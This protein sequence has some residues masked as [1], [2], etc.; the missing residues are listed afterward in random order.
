M[1][2]SLTGI[3]DRA[4]PK[5][6]TTVSQFDSEVEVEFL[7]SEANDRSFQYTRSANPVLGVTKRTTT[8][9][10]TTAGSLYGNRQ[11]R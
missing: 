9:G 2:G 3:R 5:A 1:A 11:D 10:V 8:A 6:N 4:V 7:R